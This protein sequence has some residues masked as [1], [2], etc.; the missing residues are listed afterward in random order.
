MKPPEVILEQNLVKQLNMAKSA[1]E[2]TDQLG[3]ACHFKHFVF[4]TLS[5][6]QSI[7]FLVTHTNHHLKITRDMLKK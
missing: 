3:K 5:K 7:R 6:K 1:V 2:K 4:G